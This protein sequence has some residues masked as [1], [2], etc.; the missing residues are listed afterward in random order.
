[1]KGSNIVPKSHVTKGKK[2]VGVDPDSY[3]PIMT[4]ASKE[5]QQGIK[6]HLANIKLLETDE[7][8]WPLI[9]KN[10]KETYELQREQIVLGTVKMTKQADDPDDDLHEQKLLTKLK[11]EWPFLF[12]MQCLEVHHRT[13]TKRDLAQKMK[14]FI[15]ELMDISLAFMTT[16]T[17]CN[18]DNFIIRMKLE[19]KYDAIPTDLKLISF[20]HMVANHFGES[21]DQL[22][23]PAE[24]TCQPAELPHTI[25]EEKK[26]PCVVALDSNIYAAQKYF[27]CAD[28]VP[29]VEVS[30]PKDAFIALV[31]VCFVFDLEYPPMLPLTM[32]FFERYVFDMGVLDTKCKKKG[33]QL[34][35]ISEAVKKLIASL[36]EFGE[37]RTE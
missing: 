24:R 4:S 25:L 6:E 30:N 15:D 26:D 13:L 35:V 16:S 29:L 8:D 7:I 28:Q 32:E 33:R 23:L 11:E 12:E 36:E 21:F 3:Q 17:K 10:M 2:V 27:V 22:Y 31:E 5:V 37:I 19:L 14:T 18:V 34:I 9:I 1:M 20:I